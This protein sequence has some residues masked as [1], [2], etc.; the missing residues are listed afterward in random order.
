MS[1]SYEIVQTFTVYN[2]NTG[3]YVTLH[4]TNAF[5]YNSKPI[6]SNIIIRR[7]SVKKTPVEKTPVEKTPVKRTMKL[8]YNEP[9]NALPKHLCHC[10]NHSRIIYIE[11]NERFRTICSKTGRSMR[12]CR[13]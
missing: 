4:T 8:I 1:S 12:R 9:V 6:P 10:G 11:K 2:S 7:S 5:S 13:E 3:N